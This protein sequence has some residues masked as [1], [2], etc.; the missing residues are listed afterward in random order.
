MEVAVF[1]KGVG[2]AVV[3]EAAGLRGK[4]C[5]PALPSGCVPHRDKT[6]QAHVV[7]VGGEN[8]GF[9]PCDA[10]QGSRGAEYKEGYFRMMSDAVYSHA[11]FA[12]KT[13][14]VIPLAF[15][16][17]QWKHLAWSYSDATC[18]SSR[19][20]SRQE[21][22]EHAVAT[23]PVY[24][25]RWCATRACYTADVLINISFEAPNWWALRN[26]ARFLTLILDSTSSLSCTCDCE[27]AWSSP[28]H[29]NHQVP[30]AAN[31]SSKER[32]IPEHEHHR[33]Q[34]STHNTTHTHTHT[35]PQ[36]HVSCCA[37]AENLP[38]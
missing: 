11:T 37:M 23:A 6:D 33:A 30:R 34:L 17:R 22:H 28:A 2:V 8:N 9:I 27:P 3:G 25:A 7:V 21:R 15:L 36:Y 1:V 35:R 18:M 5:V 19:A 24:I 10:C 12:G 31:S 4:V 26:C 13:G 29:T 14:A 20:R 38:M 16:A 32:H